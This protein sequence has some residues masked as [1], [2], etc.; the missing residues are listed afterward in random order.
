MKVITLPV[1]P[2]QANCYL[3]Y[4]G[5]KAAVI[6]PGDEP[7]RIFRVLQDAGLTLQ[8]IWLTHGH[9]DH[10]G[11]AERLREISGAPI[12]ACLA[13]KNLLVDPY[14]NLSRTFD[15]KEISIQADLLYADGDTFDFAGETV[16][17]LHTPGH[18][19]GSCCYRIG[20]YLFT[21]DTLF[22]GSIGRADF[23]TGDGVALQL[24]LQK[25]AAL[26]TPCAVLPGHG[27]ATTLSEER[28]NNPYM[29]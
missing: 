15:K 22:A 26:Y 10:V 18:T 11:A 6:D 21:G 7:D 27:P 14:Q 25:L 16:E 3:L 29:R 24:S 13:E 20:D 2:L 23:P 4:A 8:Q 19:S 28:N 12:I 17:V 5:T 1:G 9:F